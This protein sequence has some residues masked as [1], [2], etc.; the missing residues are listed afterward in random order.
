MSENLSKSIYEWY[1]NKDK[2]KERL[3]VL[4]EISF[5]SQNNSIKTSSHV[6]AVTGEVNN[7]PREDI[8]E[9]LSLMGFADIKD[10]IEDDVTI[11][12]VGANP[13]SGIISKAIS[14]GIKIVPNSHFSDLCSGYSVK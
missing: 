10:D 8:K 12:L 4:K 11:L 7:M 5:K 6:I 9:V 14:K 3:D 2:E 13:D 1:S